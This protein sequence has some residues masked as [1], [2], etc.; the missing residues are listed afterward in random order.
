[1]VASLIDAD[2]LVM[3]TDIDGLY[4]SNPQI[5]I[6]AKLIERVEEIDSRIQNMASRSAG[7]RGVGG[8]AT[9]I[10]AAKLATACGIPVVIANG[11]TPDNLNQI[12]EGKKVGTIFPPSSNKTESKKRWML[13]GLASKGSLI[14]DRGAAVAIRAQNK[15]LLP[16]GIIDMEG[17][18]QRG[19]V[20]NITD[21]QG[22]HLGYGISNYGSSEIAVIK[23]I[24]SKLVSKKLGYEYGSEIIH[25]NN[26]VITW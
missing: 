21:E 25:R 2:L 12:A 23:G 22:N 1:M 13:S 7:A 16:A 11:R 24:N 19:D 9:K 14:V 26:M 3:L 5:D 17:K 15:S 10:E 8:M 6:S 20:V 18:F 4:S